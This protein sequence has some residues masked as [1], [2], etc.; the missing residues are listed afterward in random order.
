[1]AFKST[2]ITGYGSDVKDGQYKVVGNYPKFGY[3]TGR[4]ILERKVGWLKLSDDA[5]WEGITC[6]EGEPGSGKTYALVEHAYCLHRLG[7]QVYT[8]GLRLPF[9]TG[10]YNDFNALCDIIDQG[11]RARTVIIMDEAPMWANNRD[12]ENF[13]AGFFMR[14][15]QVRKLGFLLI[16]SAISFEK[17][18]KNLRDQTWW[19]WRCTRS[20]FFRLF[21]RHLTVPQEMQVAFESPRAKIVTRPRQKIYD[22]YNTHGVLRSPLSQRDLKK[23]DE[24]PPQRS[25]PVLCYN[26][27]S[28]L[29]VGS[30]GWR[31]LAGGD[32]CWICYPKYDL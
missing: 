25:K 30:K 13:P 5:S 10:S 27:Q 6:Y 22:F 28:L 12:W 31:L 1:M 11:T 2:E 7:W 3:L 23:L 9:E 4:R 16:F 17:V 26:C 14:L 29:T 8:N 21:V 20:S 18:D 32:G 15:Q 24:M 19:I